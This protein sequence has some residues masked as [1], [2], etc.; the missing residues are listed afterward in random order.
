MTF[1]TDATALRLVINRN[2]IELMC[3]AYDDS[4]GRWLVNP[5]FIDPLGVSPHTHVRLR[6]SMSPTVITRRCGGPTAASSA[7]SRTGCTEPAVRSRT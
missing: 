7:T 4:D 1:I 3:R 5:M 6:V 2:Q